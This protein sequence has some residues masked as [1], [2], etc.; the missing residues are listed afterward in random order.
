MRP[1]IGLSAS[2]LLPVN[3]DVALHHGLG[4]LTRNNSGILLGVGYG[5][6]SLSHFRSIEIWATRCD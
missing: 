4:R 3:R 5:H 6:P 1:S 2:E